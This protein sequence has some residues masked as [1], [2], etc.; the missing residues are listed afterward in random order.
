MLRPASL[1]LPHLLNNVKIHHHCPKK[2]HVTSFKKLWEKK[3]DLGKMVQD[4]GKY[5]RFDTVIIV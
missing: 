2:K 1:H 4:E 5:D 3:L